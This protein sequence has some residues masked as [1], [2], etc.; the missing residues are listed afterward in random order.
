MTYTHNQ[1]QEIRD[2]LSFLQEE[3]QSRQ[4]DY[5]RYGHS[6]QISDKK[7]LH[8]SPFASQQAT[9]Q[10]IF[11]ENAQTLNLTALPSIRL[12]KKKAAHWRQEA[13]QTANP[14]EQMQ[15]FRLDCAPG[16][17]IHPAEFFWTHSTTDAITS[18]INHFDW[19]EN[20]LCI[21]TNMEH[22]GGL[23][24]LSIARYRYHIQP[25]QLGSPQTICPETEKKASDGVFAIKANGNVLNLPTGIPLSDQDQC[26]YPIYTDHYDQQ[27]FEKRLKPKLNAIVEKNQFPLKMLFFSSPSFITG[28][29]LPEKEMALWCWENHAY[30]FIDGAH[31]AGMAAIDLHDMGIDFF[32]TSG[33]KWQSAPSQTGIAYIRRG[34]KDTPLTKKL[35][36]PN[37]QLV[38]YYNNPYTNPTEVSPFWS[39]S[40]ALHKGKTSLPHIDLMT[41]LI[42]P[43][44]LE[45]QAIRALKESCQ[46][47]DF[48]GRDK[49]EHYTV[50]L[51]QY[52]RWRLSEIRPIEAHYAEFRKTKG[53]D[54]Q[55]AWH[56]LSDSQQFPTHLKTGMT[57]WQ[58]CTVDFDSQK[59]SVVDSCAPLS[60]K[61]AHQQVKQLQEI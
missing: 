35:M 30:S 42:D 18:C 27:F 41:P 9:R 3:I 29:R 61:M 38:D 5:F 50:L 20:D 12:F 55:D 14:E 23:S 26:G 10:K 47:W 43:P 54:W 59:E 32:A 28:I 40:T 58:P 22:S 56:P 57:A 2:Q 36:L 7:I 31:L 4:S 1:S 52:L 45:Y 49:I 51:A 6:A 16:F 60:A 48:V 33:H 8:E 37:G 53:T 15:F 34:K 39:I 24:A 19:K 25:A 21:Q 46:L 17:G 11:S 44:K 13:E